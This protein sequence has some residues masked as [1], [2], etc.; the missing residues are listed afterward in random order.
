MRKLIVL[1]PGCARCDRL[2]D[3]VRQAADELGLDY[4]LEKITDVREFPRY[5][6]MLTPGLVVDGQLKSQGKVP[7][8]DEVVGLIGPGATG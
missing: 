4:E 2:A 3:T 1:G 8:L 7:S 5:G 6:V